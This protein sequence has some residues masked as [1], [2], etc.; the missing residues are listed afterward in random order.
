[1]DDIQK[2]KRISSGDVMDDTSTEFVSR[3][4]HHGV[5]LVPHPSEDPLDPLVSRTFTMAKP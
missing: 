5:T 2:I 1:M 3:K 4:E